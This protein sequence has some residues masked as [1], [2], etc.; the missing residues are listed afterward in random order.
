M[1]RK[2]IKI[3]TVSYVH[4]GGRLVET[5]ELSPEQRQRL[6]YWLNCTAPN[7]VYAGRLK[8]YPTDGESREAYY[9]DRDRT[10]AYWREALSRRPQK[11]K[12]D[13]SASG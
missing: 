10:D 1:P 11:E 3:K 5:S 6:A 2:E 7:A 9:A 8:V 13:S 12:P 4:V